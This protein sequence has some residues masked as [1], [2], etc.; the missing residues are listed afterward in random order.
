MLTDRLAS[1]K[2]FIN[3]RFTSQSVRRHSHICMKGCRRSKS[4]RRNTWEG[5]KNCIHTKPGTLS[6]LSFVLVPVEWVFVPQSGGD[7][8]C[9]LLWYLTDTKL[10]SKYF[11]QTEASFLVGG[12]E[13]LPR[14]RR[15]LHFHWTFKTF[16]AGESEEHTTVFHFNSQLICALKK[17]KVVKSLLKLEP[18]KWFIYVRVQ[19]LKAL[20]S[21]KVKKVI[22]AIENFSGTGVFQVTIG[23]FTNTRNYISQLRH[24]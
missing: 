10:L 2:A 11:S 6:S 8:K 1:E 7:R 16:Q 21:P 3:Q 23:R 12:K 13:N 14:K 17:K 9:Q 20:Y 5:K 15:N 22:I 19:Q 18:V 4:L 24:I